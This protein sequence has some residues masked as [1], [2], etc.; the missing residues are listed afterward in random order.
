[1]VKIEQLDP[2]ENNEFDFDKEDEY[3][4]ISGSEFSDSDFED[5]DLEYEIEEESLLERLAALKDIIPERQRNAVSNY[6]GSVV[7][8]GRYGLSLVGKTTWVLSTTALVLLV[9][10]AL[11]MEKEQALTQYEN[12]ARLTQQG[13]Q[14]ALQPGVYPP[15]A[16]MN[17]VPGSAPATSQ[18]GLASPPGF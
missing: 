1:M 16:G 2:L 6:V 11:E 17:A 4:D 18:P 14:H 7:N 13:P 12:E 15:G 9:P 5:D 3:T 8:A 10:L